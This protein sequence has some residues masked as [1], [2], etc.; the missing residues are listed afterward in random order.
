MLMH[1]IPFNDDCSDPG[2]Q[3]H[4]GIWVAA[5]HVPPAQTRARQNTLPATPQA[6]SGP[7]AAQSRYNDNFG[8]PTLSSTGIQIRQGIRA[9]PRKTII[10]PALRQ[11][12]LVLAR[13]RIHI[14]YQQMYSGGIA[15]VAATHATEL[16]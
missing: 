13:P 7:S 4:C 14:A 15:L 10:P 5:I 1:R 9:D 16:L 8:P 3:C 12:T 6:R 2:R 11:Q